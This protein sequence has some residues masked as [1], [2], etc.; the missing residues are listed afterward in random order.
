MP[1]QQ[2]SLY[3]RVKEDSPEDMTSETLSSENLTSENLTTEVFG[4]KVVTVQDSTESPTDDFDT[5]E[6]LSK[7]LT[8]EDSMTTED[9]SERYSLELSLERIGGRRFRATGL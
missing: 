3:G 8:T 2:G 6:K 7:G 1:P 5:L 4:S 9:T